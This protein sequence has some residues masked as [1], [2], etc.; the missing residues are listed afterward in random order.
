MT[1]TVAI[2]AVLLVLASSELRSQSAAGS[3]QTPPAKVT[4]ASRPGPRQP[5]GAGSPSR[6]PTAF[7][8]Y[9]EQ[10]SRRLFAACDENGDDRITWREIKQAVKEIDLRRFRSYDAN[11]NG[12]LEFNEFDRHFRQRTRYGGQ[13]VITDQALRRLPKG[14][15]ASTDPL[16]MAW[17]S[18]MD[19]DG[20]DR[21]DFEEWKVLGNLLDK[22]PKAVF[23]LL[24]RDLSDSLTVGELEPMRKTISLLDRSR[25]EL[26]ARRKQLRP[27]PTAF[28]VADLNGDSLLD[29]DELARALRRIHPMLVRHAGRL[30]EKLDSNDDKHLDVFEL[31]SVNGAAK[32]TG[33]NTGPA[34]GRGQ[35]DP[36]R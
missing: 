24:D 10:T 2:T 17:F 9:Q 26:H 3:L 11:R 23:V 36:R 1:R 12:T 25:T 5:V 20:N 30:L 34:R 6:L 8:V 16:L 31:Q 22:N 14:A 27:L 19:V 21:L 29:K 15:A 32:G 28:R 4:G 13:L 35:N 18:T 33:N 7:G